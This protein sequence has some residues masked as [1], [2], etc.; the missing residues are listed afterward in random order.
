MLEG[1]LFP[2]TSNNCTLFYRCHFKSKVLPHNRYTSMF[3][4]CRNFLESPVPESYRMEAKERIQHLYGASNKCSL[5]SNIEPAAINPLSVRWHVLSVR[6]HVRTCHKRD[7]F[8]LRHARSHA[9][10]GFQLKAR[11]SRS[12]ICIAIKPY[13]EHVRG[14]R[15]GRGIYFY[16]LT[17][18]KRLLGLLGLCIR[19]IRVDLSA[20]V[21]YFLF[22]RM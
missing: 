19:V 9:G 5:V 14:M 17:T 16:C 2:L 4:K 7:L 1:G 6:W 15:L 18:E 10:S 12:E 20:V 22:P 3:W 11:P 13:Q 8:Y 21:L